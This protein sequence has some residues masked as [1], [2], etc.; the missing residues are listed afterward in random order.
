MPSVSELFVLC[1]KKLIDKVYEGVPKFL[2][3]LH[4]GPPDKILLF[5]NITLEILRKR[6]FW[7]IYAKS[8]GFFGHFQSI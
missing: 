8:V 6:L 5:G 2:A 3:L 7:L 4:T 1:G